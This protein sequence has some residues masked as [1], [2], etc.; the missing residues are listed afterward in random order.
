MPSNQGGGALDEKVAAAWKRVVAD[1]GCPDVYYCP[2]V[3]DI[4]CPRHSGFT[5]C[6]A[7]P[8]AHISVR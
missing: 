1:C 3:D 8:A 6:C 2:Q 7:S 5:T 4:E